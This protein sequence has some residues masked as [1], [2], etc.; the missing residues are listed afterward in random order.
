MF[1]REG[2]QL[3]GK[4][5]T[6]VYGISEDIWCHPDDPQRDSVSVAF[7]GDRMPRRQVAIAW[8]EEAENWQ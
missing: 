2:H 1:N 8:L 6:L 7:D 4:L 3:T 5:G